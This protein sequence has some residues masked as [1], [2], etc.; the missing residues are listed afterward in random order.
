MIAVLSQSTPQAALQSI[1]A[2]G[3]E[4]LLLPPHPSLPKA[5]ASHPDMLLFF[6]KD[7]IFT[8]Q[9]YYRIAKNELD[10]ISDATKKELCFVE[11]SLSSDY[12]N[13]VLFNA[14][15]MGEHLICN[16]KHTAKK[17]LDSVSGEIIDVRQGYSKC[18]TVPIAP[19]AL[20][21]ADPSIA[22]KASVFG[23][24]VLR[25]QE[26]Y[27]SLPPYSTG[28]LGGASGFAPYTKIPEIYFFGDLEFH[29]D[30]ENILAFCAKYHRKPVFL[31]PTPLFDVGTA[32]LL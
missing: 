1:R 3:Y 15:P 14:L 26:G 23:F 31:C 7:A 11:E 27:V 22:K 24:D 30:K 17:I 18:S 16:R 28:F 4:P 9:A 10:A 20:L 12:P 25:I 8:E 13:D 2:Y 29:P 19:N 5:V 21:T 32:F 6:A